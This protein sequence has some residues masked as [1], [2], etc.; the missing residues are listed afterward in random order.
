MLAGWDAY[1][2]CMIEQNLSKEEAERARQAM[3]Q[4][5]EEVERLS[6]EVQEMQRRSGP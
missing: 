3:K 5:Q 2:D 6:R 1:Y 4:L